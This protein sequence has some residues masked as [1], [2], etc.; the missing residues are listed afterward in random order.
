MRV[1]F[2]HSIGRKKF[3]GGE[4]WVI[5]A[6]AGLHNTGHSVIVAGLRNSILLKEAQQKGLQ[7]KVLNVF[8]DWNILQA[9][10]L[11]R[12]IRRNKIDVVI[13]KGRELII[14]GLAAKWANALLIR[15]NGSPPGGKSLKMKI[16]ARLFVDGVIT[17]TETIRQIYTDMGF[18]DPNYVKVLYNGLISD[19]KIT[20]FDF[21]AQYPGKSI[22]LSVGRAVAH[23]GFFYLIDALV[24]LKKRYSNLVFY[25]L[26]DGRD[27]ESL[28]QYSRE[29]GVDEMIYFA[30]YIHN[31]I[32]YFKGCDWYIHPSL[33]EGMP[34]AA[35]EAMAYGKP[36]I[37]TDVNGAAEL[38][39]NGQYAWL[40]PAQDHTAIVK[41]VTRAIENKDEFKDMGLKAQEYVRARFGMEIMVKEL[42][43]FLMERLNKKR[44]TIHS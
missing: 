25:I 21:S 36:V 38:S 15:R 19:D 30:G 22:V 1:L 6:A 29:K 23:K 14:S 42:Q 7:T 27:K 5:S 28:I 8:T 9:I 43:A 3:G 13:C 31:P 26:G 40:I 11:S 20:P 10:F 41:E 18:T 33:F 16:R 37:M 24:E 2:V 44:N 32:P 39:N 34:N 35:M 12:F 4:R 17:N